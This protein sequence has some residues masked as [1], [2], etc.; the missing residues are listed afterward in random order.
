[1][2][3]AIRTVPSFNSAA[4]SINRQ[5]LLLVLAGDAPRRFRATAH[6]TARKGLP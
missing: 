4:R 5:N 6:I 2:Q 3:R 1:M